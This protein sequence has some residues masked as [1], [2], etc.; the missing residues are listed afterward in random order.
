M[1]TQLTHCKRFLASFLQV[2][3]GTGFGVVNEC[4]A[5]VLR[6][7]NGGRVRPQTAVN[8]LFRLQSAPDQQRFDPR[9]MA[10][11]VDIELHGLLSEPLG[12]D[13]I[14]EALTVL[15]GHPTIVIEGLKGVGG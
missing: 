12:Q 2:V 15:A 7:R 5:A 9:L 10:A 3:G 14:A 4:S 8:L 11:E 6:M 1:P 13:G